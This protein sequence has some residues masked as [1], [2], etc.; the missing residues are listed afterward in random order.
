M[1]KPLQNEL[2]QFR[3]ILSGIG[4]LQDLRSLDIDSLFTENSSDETFDTY[5]KKNFN[6]ET[7]VY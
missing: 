6:P 1:Y 5:I 4:S 3:P 7:L 2:P